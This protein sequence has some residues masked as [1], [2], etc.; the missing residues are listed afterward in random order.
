MNKELENRVKNNL[1]A[2]VLIVYD[3]KKRKGAQKLIF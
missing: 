3:D 2:N 1:G